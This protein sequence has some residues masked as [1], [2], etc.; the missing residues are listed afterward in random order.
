MLIETHQTSR[1]LDRYPLSSKVIFS[2]LRAVALFMYLAQKLVHLCM[3][4]KPNKSVQDMDFF[5]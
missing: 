2:S 4:I 3:L 1:G 5:Q